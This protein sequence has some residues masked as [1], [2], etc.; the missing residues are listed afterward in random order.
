MRKLILI[1]GGGHCKSCIDVIEAEGKYKIEGIL[2]V[3]DSVGSNV[4][5]YTIKGDDTLIDQHIE[6]GFDF[7]IT[8][9]Q[10]KS[11]EK[12]KA[13]YHLIK[14]KKGNLATVLSPSAIISKHSIIGEGTIVMNGVHINCGAKVGNNAILNTGCLIEHD[15]VVGDHVHVSTHAVINGGAIIRSDCFIGSNA[16]INQEIVIKGDAVIGAGSVVIANVDE[17]GIY[18][19]NP[20]KRLSK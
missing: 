20:A 11:A 6:Q 12:R 14:S 16:V 9:G 5:G 19:G 8:I 1:G 4:L 13:L 18:A 7:L 3:T 17:S 2:D 15:V 10:I